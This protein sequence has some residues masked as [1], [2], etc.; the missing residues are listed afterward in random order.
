MKAEQLSLDAELERRLVEWA[1]WFLQGCGYRLGYPP[2]SSTF[3]ACYQMA[4]PRGCGHSQP[5]PSHP[6]AEEVE[7]WVSEMSK[8]R[9]RL[10]EVLRIQYFT[11]GYKFDKAR[12][13]DL[14]LTQYN[15]ALEV[16]KSWLIA[17]LLVKRTS[18]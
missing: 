9:P 4:K 2:I 8:W 11:L 10:A 15:V 1:E 6:S 16:S 3:W 12:Q 17:R 7:E 5:L 14:S 18:G 13:L